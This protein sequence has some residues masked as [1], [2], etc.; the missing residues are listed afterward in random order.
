V[1]VVIS[2][3]D[4]GDSVF[5]TVRGILASDYPDFEIRIVDQ[6][7]DE[8]TEGALKPLLEDPRVRY[9]RTDTKGLSWGLNVG[10][11]GA[12]SEIIAI[13]G[14]DCEIP[15]DWLRAIVTAFRFDPRIGIVFGNVW[16]GS[17]DRERGFVPGYVR[18]GAELAQSLR[19]KHR[20]GGTSACM[21]LRR[22]VWEVLGGFD[23]M[24][25][26]GARFHSAEDTDL[27]LRA[28]SSG[29][30]VYETPEVSVVHHG[31]YGWDQRMSLVHRYWYGTGAAF[32]KQLRRGR[33]DAAIV[34]LRLARGWVS[35]RSRVARSFSERPHRLRGGLSFV[36][37]VVSGAFTPLDRSSGHYLPCRSARRLPTHAGPSPIA[38]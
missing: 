34:L 16:P 1:T 36:R 23:P 19:E 27:T 29:Y 20:I 6:S 18:E 38:L 12:Q 26:A 15:K 25:G 21:G 14:D 3:R 35:S 33:W 8:R 28:L 10:I 32:M 37:G 7:E 11:Q 4:K 30:L 13:T 5:A 17:H 31:F 24:L 2:T 22:S 9:L